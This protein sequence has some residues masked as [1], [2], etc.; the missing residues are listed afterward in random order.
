MDMKVIATALVQ[1]TYGLEQVIVY[2]QGRGLTR[3][4]AP[5]WRRMSFCCPIMACR[6]LASHP[7]FIRFMES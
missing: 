2:Q 1:G 3:F 4:Y 6:K 7:K 5:M